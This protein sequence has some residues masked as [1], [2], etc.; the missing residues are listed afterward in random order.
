MRPVAQ[1]HSAAWLD[2]KR[3]MLVLDFEQAHLP[4]GYG[5]PFEVRQLE[6]HDQGR[7]M[8]LEVRTRALRF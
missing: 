3:G 8:P 5:A 2:G 1:A 6:L 7:M 4:V